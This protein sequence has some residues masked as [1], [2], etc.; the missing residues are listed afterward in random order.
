MEDSATELRPRFEP[1]IGSERAATERKTV[2]NEER[3]TSADEEQ[4][5]P[6]R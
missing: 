4:R 6:N 3:D 1:E 5:I 2:T